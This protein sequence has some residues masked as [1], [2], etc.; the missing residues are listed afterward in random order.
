[1]IFYF[2]LGVWPRGDLALLEDRHSLHDDLTRQLKG[3]GEQDWS[4]RDMPSKL[5]NTDCSN[6][7]SLAPNQTTSSLHGAYA[8]NNDASDAANAISLSVSGSS[9]KSD[10]SPRESAAASTATAE[11]NWDTFQPDGWGTNNANPPPQTNQRDIGT[12]SPL[13]IQSMHQQEP[14]SKGWNAVD[15]KIAFG[16]SKKEVAAQDN[17]ATTRISRTI[18]IT[19]QP[20]PSNVSSQQLH[21]I[22]AHT[23]ISLNLC[24]VKNQIGILIV[25]SGFGDAIVDLF[26]GALLFGTVVSAHVQQ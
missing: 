6:S 24:N 18:R 1:V 13:P 3:S 26:D 15:G 12:A 5:A 17:S 19:I 8:A 4:K 20:L 9:C 2:K 25:D 11:S 7:W 21:D 22:I 16:H 23:G 10:E 14:K